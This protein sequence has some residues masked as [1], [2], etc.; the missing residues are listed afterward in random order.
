[1]GGSFSDVSAP[2]FIRASI[3]RAES[4]IEKMG[5]APNESYLHLHNLYHPAPLHAIRQAKPHWLWNQPPKPPIHPESDLGGA[6]KKKSV[7]RLVI[8]LLTSTLPL[9]SS[10]SDR[11]LTDW[12]YSSTHS[13]FCLAASPHF[14][15][16][17]ATLFVF[18]FQ[19]DTTERRASARRSTMTYSSENV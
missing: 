8:I 7:R 2:I 18:A 3:W 9:A 16:A 15:C 14:C 1:M 4:C 6:S 11:A 5:K 17:P 13:R 19:V 12:Q 10:S